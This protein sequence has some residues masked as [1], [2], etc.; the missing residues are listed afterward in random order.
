[1]TD[2]SDL[3]L[4]WTE[5]G[6]RYQGL[7]KETK[8]GKER[9]LI[10]RSLRDAGEPV[11]VTYISAD[12]GK[13][14]NATRSLL[15]KMV[16]GGLVARTSDGKYQ[17]PQEGRFK[18]D[19]DEEDTVTSV[20]DVSTVM[21]VTSVMPVMPV[22]QE[23]ITVEEGTV[24]PTVMQGKPS[25]TNGLDEKHNDIT[26]I[27]PKRGNLEKFN[28]GSPSLAEKEA[29]RQEFLRLYDSR[30]EFDMVTGKPIVKS[31]E[32]KHEPDLTSAV[33]IVEDADT[34]PPKTEAQEITSP[35]SCGP[36]QAWLESQPE[37]T[38]ALYASKLARLNSVGI[39]DAEKLALQRTFEEVASA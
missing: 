16:K 38:K 30:E 21:P 28:L 19:D 20:T 29:A 35:P 31:L 22:M 24:M 5:E 10:L 27:T 2:D 25:D 1:M 13:T 14:A 6:W 39:P 23:N 3:A 33:G 26:H 8:C 17:I 12:I 11:S 4:E 37:A 15:F 36:S 9:L 32:I 18:D 7:A 34:N